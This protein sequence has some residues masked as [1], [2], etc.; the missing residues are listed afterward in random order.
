MSVSL[1][2]GIR[3]WRANN[4]VSPSGAP[5]QPLQSQ[6]Q[7]L[8]ADVAR[9]KEA[10]GQTSAQEEVAGTSA[11]P[12]L[13]GL[14]LQGTLSAQAA[15]ETLEARWKA[16]RLFTANTTQ[17][18]DFLADHGL[19]TLGYKDLLLKKAAAKLQELHGHGELRSCASLTWSN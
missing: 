13:R 8:A 3:R 17:L 12:R 7:P 18:K 1:G 16:M 19:S 4:S 6:S 2:S 15:A 10:A 11:P 9:Q 14:R 5:T